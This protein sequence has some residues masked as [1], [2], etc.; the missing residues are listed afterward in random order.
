M[1]STTRTA[2]PCGSAPRFAIRLTMEQVHHPQRQR[3]VRTHHRQVQ[4]LLLRECQQSRQI[5]RTDRHTSHLPARPQGLPGDACVPRRAPH[6]RH[7]RGLRH[8]P[9][10]CMLAPARTDHQNLHHPGF[11]PDRRALCKDICLLVSLRAGIFPI[12]DFRSINGLT[13]LQ[14]VSTAHR[15]LQV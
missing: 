1:P 13:Q 10:Q 5:L 3:I 4:L 14:C 11:K 12:P 9:H 7:M 2:P 6:L 15:T 8:L